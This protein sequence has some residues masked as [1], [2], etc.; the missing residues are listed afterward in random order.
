MNGIAREVSVLNRCALTPPDIAAI[1]PTVGDTFA[2]KLNSAEACPRFVGRV[3]RDIDKTARSPLWLTERLRRAGVR[4]LGPVVDITN[5][6]M[7]ELNQP[8]HAYDLNKL[9]G[10][11]NVRWSQTGEQLQL[12]NEQTVTLDDDT[13]LITDER[14][15]IG[16]AGIMGGA[17]TEV[18]DNSCDIFFECAFFTPIK[19]A[20]RARRYGLHT[21]ASQRFERGVNPQGQMQAVERATR[22]LIE[23]AGGQPGPLIDTHVDEHLPSSPTVKLRA[24]RLERILGMSVPPAEVEDILTRLGMKVESLADGWQATPPS[25]RFDI[26]REEDLIEEVGRIRGYNQLPQGTS[27]SR[28]PLADCPEDHIPVTRLRE[29]LIQR[30]YQEIISYSFIDPS[31]QQLFDPEQPPIPLSNPISAEMAVMRTQ[32]WPG[33]IKTLRYNQARQQQRV[34]IFEAGLTFT[35][36]LTAVEQRSYLGGLICGSA[37][38]EQWGSP[39]RN[40]DFFDLKNDVEALLA[41]TGYAYTYH[42]ASHP[43]LHPGQSARIEQGGQAIGWL[44]ALH[45]SLQNRLELEQIVYLFELNLAALQTAKT[46]QAHELSKFPQSRRDLSLVVDATVSAQAVTKALRQ[47]GGERLRR[48]E[49]FDVYQ[50]KGID[51]NQKSLAF[52]LIFQ[53]FSSSLTDQEIDQTIAK[54]IAG[55][56]QDLGANLRD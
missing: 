46:P 43:A 27:Q 15:P 5:Y 39:R 47:Y 28:L 35:G 11:I 44:G 19:I 51:E 33:L 12:L 1:S 37:L 17:T 26:E 34:R 31:L 48:V 36:S 9:Q 40:I 21:D 2:I 42:P 13:L 3:I 6:V 16:L 7:L 24:Q 56:K 14:G 10:A 23:I 41:A 22:L 38:S 49:L 8:M 4:S 55:I 45:P 52:S 50:G 32:L 18:D 54:I 30:D 53:D 25:N 29:T 20:G